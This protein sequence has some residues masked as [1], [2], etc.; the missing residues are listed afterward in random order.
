[1]KG[2]IFLGIVLGAE[3]VRRADLRAV[4]GLLQQAA[5]VLRLAEIDEATQRP[6][7]V[8]RRRVDED[9]GLRALARGIGID[10]LADTRG[11]VATLQRQLTNQQV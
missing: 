11:V 3:R 7:G 5:E 4:Q 1:M 8:R 6:V 10:S 9:A 2:A